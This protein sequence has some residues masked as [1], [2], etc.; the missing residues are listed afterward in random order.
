LAEAE[1]TAKNLSTILTGLSVETEKTT[2]RASILAGQL[3]ETSLSLIITREK[4]AI[5]A[6][7][8]EYIIC[9]LMTPRIKDN[10]T[11]TVKITC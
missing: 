11:Q 5:I 8:N 6:L 3:K 9:H 2:K 1:N 4:E 7:K 10:T